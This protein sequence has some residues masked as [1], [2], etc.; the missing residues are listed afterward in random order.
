MTVLAHVVIGRAYSRYFFHQ[1]SSYQRN[2]MCPSAT[3]ILLR[4]PS[5]M[6]GVVTARRQDNRVVVV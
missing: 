6:I 3:Y 1:I 2:T 4:S 5:S